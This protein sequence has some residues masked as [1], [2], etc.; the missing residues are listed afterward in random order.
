MKSVKLF[1][2]SPLAMEEDRGQAELLVR[3]KNDAWTRSGFQLEFTSS[4]VGTTSAYV[5]RSQD[6]YNNLIQA[7]DLFVLLCSTK[8]GVGAYSLE[9]FEVAV[10]HAHSAK[11][12]RILVF[13]KDEPVGLQDLRQPAVTRLMSFIDRLHELEVFYKTYATSGELVLH[14]ER[15]LDVW[16]SL[17][18]RLETLEDVTNLTLDIDGELLEAV[19]GM[20]FV[21][22]P[23]RARAYE[24][25]V[26]DTLS[27]RGFS[28]PE[29]LNNGLPQA[30]RS[31]LDAAVASV[32]LQIDMDAQLNKI[33][34]RTNQFELQIRNPVLMWHCSCGMLAGGQVDR[35]RRASC[36]I[37]GAQDG[38]VLTRFYRSSLVR[39]SFDGVDVIWRRSPEVWPPTIDSFGL[40]RDMEQDGVFSRPIR[41]VLDIGC[42]T[43]ILGLLVG[44]KNPDVRRIYLADWLLTPLVYSWLATCI[45]A[46]KLTGRKVICL[47]GMQTS[48]L[49]STEVV[50]QVDLCVCNPPYLPI[51]REFPQMHLAHTVAG[52]DLLEH[53][54]EHASEIAKT[55][56]IS[57]SDV[58]LDQA[59]SAAERGRRTLK[60]VGDGRAI[61]FT[62]PQAFQNR[63]YV[64]KLSR[65]NKIFQRDDSVFP[66]W[67]VIKTYRIDAQ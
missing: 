45:N 47:L 64:D 18:T 7:A 59:T 20:S 26:R 40:C 17:A 4:D 43:G 2:A 23:R 1:L 60:A 48:W 51:L 25:I 6:N 16:W 11:R 53:V 66:W 63:D 22:A 56:Y 52:T 10:T 9:E 13:C 38:D 21:S 3:R 62:V 58:A 19:R 41:S 29:F 27:A 33:A 12:P 35:A 67:H 8:L 24:A 46:Q 14:L 5:T 55:T 15:E 61:P 32:Q 37:H 49:E 44:I 39:T 42:G 65:E 57:F 36:A 31:V 28:C 50:G 30:A 54:V 34:Y